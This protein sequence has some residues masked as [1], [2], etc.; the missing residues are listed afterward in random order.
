MIKI[1]FEEPTTR[2]WK[3]WR[4]ACK[5]ATDEIVA[6]VAN[7][8]SPEVKDVY[9]RKSIKKGVFFSKTGPFSGKCA[10]CECYITDFQHGDV[11]HYRPKKGVTDEDD[12]PIKRVAGDGSQVEHPGYYW[13]A[14]DWQNLLPS[15]IA[16]NQ[17]TKV[18]DTKIGK[19]NRFPVTGTHAF[20]QSSIG[21]EKPLLLNPLV[22]A[23]ED[24][25]EIDTATG[26]MVEKS[27]RGKMSIQI[28]GLNLRDRL[29]E[30]RLKAIG[31]VKVA[32][33]K[34]LHNPSLRDEATAELKAIVDGE[35]EYAFAARAYLAEISPSLAPYIS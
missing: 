14:Y 32:I 25:L 2:I 33:D 24:H 10:Y 13:L 9:R 29:P 1:T 17:A 4:T 18:D 35:T 16:C 15:C 30:T 3:L 7:G 28:F 21:S 12:I 23:P 8:H 26:L 22:D 19:H 34:I 20:D 11:E 31:Q 27:D 6:A 5:K